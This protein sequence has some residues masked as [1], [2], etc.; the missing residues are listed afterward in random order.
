MY[1][2]KANLEMAALLTNIV[3]LLA[4]Y[5]DGSFPAYTWVLYVYTGLIID[6]QSLR[7]S[8]LL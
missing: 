1:E 8:V 7:V 2:Y 6:P 4:E 3:I 5:F